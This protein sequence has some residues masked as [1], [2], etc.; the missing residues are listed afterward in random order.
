MDSIGYL[1][2]EKR[3]HPTGMT[4]EK[5]YPKPGDRA[6][7]GINKQALFPSIRPNMNPTGECQEYYISRSL[8]VGKLIRNGYMYDQPIMSRYHR[9]E[10]IFFIATEQFGRV[11]PRRCSEIR[12]DRL[13]RALS[14]DQGTYELV[15]SE[16]LPNILHNYKANCGMTTSGILNNRGRRR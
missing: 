3:I 2:M 6:R 10:T 14:I 13:P 16:Y 7:T 5:P 11:P 4:P 8:L 9:F 1:R 12:I 15:E